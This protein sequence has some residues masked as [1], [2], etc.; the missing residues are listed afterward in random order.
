M[1]ERNNSTDMALHLASDVVVTPHRVQ[2]KFSGTYFFLL[3]GCFTLG[4]TDIQRKLILCAMVVG[5][6]GKYGSKKIVAGRTLGDS[7]NS[8]D[9]ISCTAP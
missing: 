3:V 6:S 8:A 2:R 9:M 4:V 7:S 5:A 1:L